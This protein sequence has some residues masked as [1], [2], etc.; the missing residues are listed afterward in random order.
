MQVDVQQHPKGLC[1]RTLSSAIEEELGDAT[2]SP[3]G[4]PTPGKVYLGKSRARGRVYT[5]ILTH[6]PLQASVHKLALALTRFW[7]PT[8][9]L[10]L[11][12]L[13]VGCPAPGFLAPSFI[14]RYPSNREFSTV[15]L[16]YITE[17]ISI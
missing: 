11:R 12:Q 15:T 14:H 4:V 2:G 13:L 9:H 6:D 1:K 17:D 5:S 8:Y 16:L 7:S 3:S 10:L